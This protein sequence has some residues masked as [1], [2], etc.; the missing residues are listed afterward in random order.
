MIDYSDHGVVWYAMKTVYK[1]E[2]H[3]KEY[4]DSICIENYI[5]MQQKV[6]NKYGRKKV[7]LTPVVHNLIF[8]KTD[9]TRLNN[10]KDSIRYLHNILTTE[11]D[12]SI[13]IIVPTQQMDQFIDAMSCHQDEVTYIDLTDT[14]IEK[15]TPIRVTDGKFKGYEGELAKVKGKRNRLVYV[16][17][18]GVA[19]YKFETE[20]RFI[21][22]L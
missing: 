17:L 8:V 11:D 3:A 12:I 22:R 4:L 18:K 21:E 7:T 1:K 13:P 14:Y 19:A 20:V 5:P 2:L 16:V 15:G 10:I 6:E 9:L